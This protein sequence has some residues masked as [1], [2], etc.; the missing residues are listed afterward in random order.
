MSSQR[1]LRR[2][3]QKEK[4]KYLQ[5]FMEIANRSGG[6]IV[7]EEKVMQKKNCEQQRPAELDKD[8]NQCDENIVF[9]QN[10][11]QETNCE[12]QTPADIDEDMDQCDESLVF[13]ENDKCG[14]LNL[15]DK[16]KDWF[17]KYKPPRKCVEELARILREEKLDVK[18]FYKFACP[19]KPQIESIC[20]GSM[21]H[22]GIAHQFKKF[23]KVINLPENVNI[24]V[25]VDGLPLYRSSKAQLW[26]ILIRANNITS[27]PVFAVSVFL[28]RTKPSNLGDYLDMFVLELG[29]V[30]K[31]GIDLSGKIINISL[32]AI[33]CDAPARAF[34]SGTPSHVSRHGCSKCTQI[35]KK[36]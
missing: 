28:G 34:I 10:A 29:D 30:M 13:E 25:N 8:N 3:I 1:Q 17:I 2:L 32:R 9:V 20:G 5:R 36:N 33:I 14:V 27:E 6:N 12:L 26:P 4:E 19:I 7:V 22:I 23:D 35:A 16:L 11:A 24:D 18:M 31:N 21:L 15:N